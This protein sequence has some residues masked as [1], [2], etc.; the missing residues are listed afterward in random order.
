MIADILKLELNANIAYL[1]R[2]V[3]MEGFG[4][5]CKLLNLHLP[6]LLFWHT[7]PLGVQLGR[8]TSGIC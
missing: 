6:R 2:E 7:P 8:M 1:V 3:D 4:R 5:H